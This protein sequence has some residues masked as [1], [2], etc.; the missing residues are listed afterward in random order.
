MNLLGFFARLLIWYLRSQFFV[1]HGHQLAFVHQLIKVDGVNI[2]IGI[3]GVPLQRD[4][5]KRQHKNEP[6]EESCG[7]TLV[8]ISPLSLLLFHLQYN[9]MRNTAFK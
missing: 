4:I 1:R 5:K 8:D 7:T 6:Q 9:K 3:N 2:V